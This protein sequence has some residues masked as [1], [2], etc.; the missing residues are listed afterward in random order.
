[1]M[2]N[3]RDGMVADDRRMANMPRID[4]LSDAEFMKSQ[5]EYE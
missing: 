4:D 2:V 1:V 5:V 3:P